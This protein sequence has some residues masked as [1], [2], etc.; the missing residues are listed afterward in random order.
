[1]KNDQFG[2]VLGRQVRRSRY[3]LVGMFGAISG[4]EYVVKHDEPPSVYCYLISITAL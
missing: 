1:M 3:G 4:D 2:I